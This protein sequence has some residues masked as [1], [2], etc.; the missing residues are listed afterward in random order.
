MEK[1]HM[2]YQRYW[3]EAGFTGYR[4]WDIIPRGNNVTRVVIQQFSLILHKQG[5]WLWARLITM[6]NMS[7]RVCGPLLDCN[8]TGDLSVLLR[9]MSTQWQLTLRWNGLPVSATYCWPHLLHETEYITLEDLQEARI[10]T[11]KDFQSYGWRTRPRSP[12]WDRFYIQVLHGDSCRGGPC[13][14]NVR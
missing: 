7:A 9:T 10:L 3:R 13:G 4:P 8:D 1:G 11:L 14:V 12:V 6:T 5:S 2:K